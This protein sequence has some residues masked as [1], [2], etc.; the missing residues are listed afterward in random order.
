VSSAKWPGRSHRVPERGAPVHEGDIGVVEHASKS[1][2]VCPVT[3]LFAGLEASETHVL[4]N[5]EE[6]HEVEVDEDGD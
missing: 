2:R 4:R 1:Q 5:Q 6:D 3:P